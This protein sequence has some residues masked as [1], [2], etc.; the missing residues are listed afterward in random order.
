[1][2]N[3]LQQPAMPSGVLH[4][5]HSQPLHLNA[6]EN[7]N[8]S[9]TWS[10]QV[11]GYGDHFRTLPATQGYNL[12]AREASAN[13]SMVKQVFEATDPLSFDCAHNQFLLHYAM[14]SVHVENK[15]AMETDCKSQDVNFARGS[16]DPRVLAVAGN[17]PKGIARSFGC[18]L[19]G[20]MWKQATD[21][22]FANMMNN[23][24]YELAKLKHVLQKQQ[25]D[26]ASVSIGYTHVVNKLKTM[27]D[28]YG[29][30]CVDKPKCRCVYDGRRSEKYI[31]WTMNFA[32][33]VKMDTFRILMALGGQ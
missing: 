9:N 2:Q 14:N 3:E 27:D 28:G 26:P 12:R 13:L 4:Q 32:P 22:E 8:L 30:T 10:Q 21:K 18:K 17:E 20:G 1:M 11:G 16:K 23:G 33:V 25:Q 31:D 5:M 29:N 7:H 6:T 15:V 19:L 24:T